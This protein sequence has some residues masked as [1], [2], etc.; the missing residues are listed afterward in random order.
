MTQ[1]YD[2]II[3]FIA[4]KCEENDI[5]F[6][7]STDPQVSYDGSDLKVN[8][9][10]SIEPHPILSVATGKPH[11][12]WVPTL[13]H[14]FSHS[15]QWLENHPAWSDCYIDGIDAGSLCENW[16]AHEVEY[17]FEEITKIHDKL[18][19]LELDCERRALKFIKQFNV[20]LDLV[21]YAQKAGSYVMFYNIMSYTRKWYTIGQEPYNIKEIW[22]SMP[23]TLR[24][25]YNKVTQKHLDVYSIIFPE[26]KDMTPY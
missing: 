11:Q 2:S 17:T 6:I 23:T 21:E 16:L 14:E 18:K 8:G 3:A 13:I 10:F 20:P 12:E 5:E 22:Q 7:L 1:M 4:T 26:L 19:Y 25:R 9:Y 24:G 15:Q